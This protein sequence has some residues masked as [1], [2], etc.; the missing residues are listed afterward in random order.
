[1]VWQEHPGVDG[2]G[3]LKANLVDCP[4]Q[5]FPAFSLGEQGNPPMG[6]HGEEKGAAGLFG[7][8]II[9]HFSAIS[10]FFS[11]GGARPT[12]I[13]A[14]CAQPIFNGKLW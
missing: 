8:P 14:I 7:P 3:M 12:L 11:A 2:E 5:D 4:A 13:P 6:N 1:M 10:K 9:G